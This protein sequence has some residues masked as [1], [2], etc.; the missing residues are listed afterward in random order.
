MFEVG[1]KISMTS[2]KLISISSIFYAQNLT[3]LQVQN[4]HIPVILNILFKSK[5]V[6]FLPVA[7][8]CTGTD[9]TTDGALTFAGGTPYAD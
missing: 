1:H 2:D 5:R 8:H 3:R 6:S 7:F 9:W 4:V